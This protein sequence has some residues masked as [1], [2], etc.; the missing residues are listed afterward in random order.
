MGKL[1]DSLQRGH[2]V[3]TKKRNYGKRIF[4][5]GHLDTVFEPN[6]CQ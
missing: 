5:I 4:I 6:A 1:P 2:L 3:A